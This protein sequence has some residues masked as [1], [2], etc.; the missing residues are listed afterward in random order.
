MIYPWHRSFIIIDTRYPPS[1]N[2]NQKQSQGYF[3]YTS[4]P[5]LMS[6]LSYN[7]VVSAVTFG[8]PSGDEY[9]SAEEGR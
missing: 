9:Y 8:Y 7:L 6:R 1:Q 5:P 4:V 2:L 3:Y